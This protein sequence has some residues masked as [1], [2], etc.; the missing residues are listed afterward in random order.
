[1]I[2]FVLALILLLCAVPLLVVR[3]APRLTA[4]DAKGRRVP[5]LPPLPTRRLGLGLLAAGLLILLLST[6]RVVGAT[7]I[8]IPVTFGTVGEPLPAGIHLVAPWTD[9]TVLDLRLTEYTMTRAPAEGSIGGDDSIEVI[10]RDQ[11]RLT[12]DATVRYAIDPGQARDIF[13][14]LGTTDEQFQAKALRPESRSAIR[15]AASRFGAIE[16]LAERRAEYAEIVEQDIRE[17]LEPLGIIVDTVAL[18][19]VTPSP[20]LQAAADAKL[21]QE[22]A[23]ERAQLELAEAEARAEIRRTEAQGEADANRILSESLTPE[24]LQRLQ[25]EAYDE[26]SVFVVPQGGA[27]LLLQ[28]PAPGAA[29]PE[30]GG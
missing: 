9:I 26:G 10:S 20:E 5:A 14:R 4:P 27:D 3:P 19:D 28:P 18:R 23:N 11:G 6:L 2:R 7:S 8:G 17:R 15:E 13:R 16:L 22:Q 25:I 30:G 12:V 21:Q 1:M 24:L 29:S